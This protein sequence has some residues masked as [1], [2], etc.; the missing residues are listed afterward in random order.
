VP[1]LCRFVKRRTGLASNKKTSGSRR[2]PNARCSMGQ[3]NE[4]AISVTIGGPKIEGLELMS[5]VVPEFD[6]AVHSSLEGTLAN[7]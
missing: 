5:P 4:M 3:V 2:V 7:P 1:L 6:A